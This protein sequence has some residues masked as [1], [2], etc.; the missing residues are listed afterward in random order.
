MH[1]A[2]GRTP[3]GSV[4]G[5]S[6]THPRL[7]VRGRAGP[8]SASAVTT[9]LLALFFFVE[10]FEPFSVFRLLLAIVTAALSVR[11]AVRGTLVARPEGIEWH[12]MM[13]T[14]HFPYAAVSHFDLAVNPDDSFESFK[15]VARIHLVDGHAQWLHGLERPSDPD[16]QVGWPWRRTGGVSGSDDLESQL[17]TLNRIVDDLRRG[18]AHREAG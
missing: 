6:E 5:L 15:R 7:T 17:D 16:L 12:T 4:R 14:R 9:G 3:A 11:L 1:D 8:L 2:S 18:R 10:A 13:R